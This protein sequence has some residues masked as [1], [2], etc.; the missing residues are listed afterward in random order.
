MKKEIIDILKKYKI[1]ILLQIAFIGLN[2]YLLTYPPKI[3]GDIVDMLYNLDANKQ[4]I[5]IVHIT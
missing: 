1:R 4:N 3:I 2:I 5:L